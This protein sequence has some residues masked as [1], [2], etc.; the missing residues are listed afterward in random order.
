[1]IGC[2]RGD[3][4]SPSSF[5]KPTSLVRKGGLEPARPRSLGAVRVRRLAFQGRLRFPGRVPRLVP[6]AAAARSS[7]A[8]SPRAYGVS[9][10]SRPPLPPSQNLQVW[11]ER[12]DSNPHGLPHRI[13][14]P[15]RLPV[16]P[17]SR[18]HHPSAGQAPDLH[19]QA[20][21]PRLTAASG[22]PMPPCGFGLVA[23]AGGDGRMDPKGG[24]APAP[25]RTGDLRL[26]RPTLYPAE[27]RAQGGARNPDGCV[28][29]RTAP[30]GNGR[31]AP[32]S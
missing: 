32:V 19:R 3:L 2:E 7:L 26:R 20:P 25:T 27:L 28:Y 16:P 14:S 18:G 5:A 17:L 11:C 6:M 1:M 13:L 10:P 15:A 8:L 9:R 21:A 31:E 29:H 23:T 24:G 12:G 4:S 22:H 30:R